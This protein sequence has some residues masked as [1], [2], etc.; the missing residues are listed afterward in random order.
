MGESVIERDLDDAVY[1]ISVEFSAV[2]AG[3]DE[4]EAEGEVL[5]ERGRAGEG[6]ALGQT[7][8][9]AKGV[10]RRVCGHF[11]VARWRARRRK[12]GRRRGDG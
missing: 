7:T 8:D 6:R 5:R 9:A 1:T 2:D 11:P 10:G 4:L 12:S 3:V